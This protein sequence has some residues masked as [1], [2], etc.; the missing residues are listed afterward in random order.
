MEEKRFKVGEIF[1]LSDDYQ[2]KAKFCNDNNLMIVELERSEGAE[3]RFQIQ[4]I[5]NPTKKELASQRIYELKSQLSKYK[6]D[7][8][9]VELFGMERLDYEDK[10]GVCAEIIV[11]LRELEQQLEVDNE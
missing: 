3:R 11:E 6:E 1:E 9:Q 5:P 4:E 10:K 2:E 7:V 8:E